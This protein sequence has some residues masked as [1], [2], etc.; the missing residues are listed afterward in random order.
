MIA[1]FTLSA[2]Q[3]VKVQILLDGKGTVYADAAQLEN[4]AFA[5]AYNMLENGNFERGTSG[6]TCSTGVSSSTGTRFNMSKALYMSGDLTSSRYAYQK[7][8]VKTNRATRETFTLSGWAKGYGIV[9]RE[10][11]YAQAPAIQT[12]CGSEVLRYLL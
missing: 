10:R 6:W 3:S 5:N 12:A 1:P 11:D 4:N 7:V 9:K 2:A 8:T